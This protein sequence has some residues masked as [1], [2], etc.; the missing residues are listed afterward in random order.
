MRDLS[1]PV[2]VYGRSGCGKTSVL[3]RIMDHVASGEWKANGVRRFNVLARFLGKF[4]F[5]FFPMIH[6][7]TEKDIF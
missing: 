2:V 5:I 7:K 4:L 3:A 1:G 6:D